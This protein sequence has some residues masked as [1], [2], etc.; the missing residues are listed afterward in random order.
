[1]DCAS[2]AK[3]PPTAVI[4]FEIENMGVLAYRASK[5][6]EVCGLPLKVVTGYMLDNES[7]PAY[8]DAHLKC[9]WD[10]TSSALYELRLGVQFVLLT[11]EGKKIAVKETEG[12]FNK[13]CVSIGCNIIKWSDLFDDD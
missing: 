2:W 9:V 7:E 1:S 3:T 5:A 13:D 8:V 11:Q 10:D 6:Q 12:A 4:R